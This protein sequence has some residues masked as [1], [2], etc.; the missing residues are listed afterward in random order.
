MPKKDRIAQEREDAADD[1]GLAFDELSRNGVVGKGEGPSANPNHGPWLVGLG[2]AVA[3][4]FVLMLIA[5]P[6][7][8]VSTSTPA[9]LPDN[10]FTSIISS[11]QGLL[12]PSDHSLPVVLSK[13]LL[14]ALLGTI[15]GYRQRVDVDEYIVQAHVIIAFTGALM[16]IIIGNEIVRAFGLV[17]AG[18]IIRYRTPVRDPRALASLFVTMGIGIAVGVG[19]FEL[20]FIGA[21]LIVLIQGIFGTIAGRLPHTFYNPQRGYS[22]SLWTEDG[23]GTLQRVR[24]TFAE[25]DIRYRLLEYDARSKKDGL[26]KMALAVEA[27]AHLSTEDLTL[28]VFRDGVQ[29]VSW[30]EG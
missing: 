13:L 11:V 24:Q 10:E 25:H 4:A 30:E 5:L 9:A 14:A 21:V 27:S 20:A 12:T 1:P 8:R 23:A 3:L 19:L 7:S 2:M 18:S 6:S 22:L 29:S 17:G 15:V 16:M 28:L 26:V